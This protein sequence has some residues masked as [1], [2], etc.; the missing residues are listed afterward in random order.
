LL[1]LLILILILPLLH[2]PL[3]FADFH[4]LPE[5]VNLAGNDALL[6]VLHVVQPLVSGAHALEE[7]R[8]G[9]RF[10]LYR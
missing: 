9:R 1:L 2:L 8:A 5:F 3:G 10:S 7:G 6:L 4:G